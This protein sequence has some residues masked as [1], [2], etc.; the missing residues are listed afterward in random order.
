M[1][2]LA[3][4][5]D[6]VLDDDVG[7]TKADENKGATITNKAA[8]RLFRLIFGA[9]LIEKVDTGLLKS[10]SVVAGWDCIEMAMVDSG[11]KL[12]VVDYF[13]FHC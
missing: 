3:R 9:V 7:M 4:Q 5:G 12:P 6:V 11:Q 2:E 10:L 8:V 1:P 13:R